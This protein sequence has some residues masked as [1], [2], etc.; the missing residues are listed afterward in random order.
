MT[1]GNSRR[2]NYLDAIASAVHARRPDWDF[3][4][5]KASLG[6][7]AAIAGNSSDLIDVG[8]AALKATQRRDR[9]SPS[10][11]AEPGTHWAGTDTAAAITPPRPC[12]NH[13]AEPAHACRQCR[14]EATP[15]PD[16]V[17]ADL[18]DIF[19]TRRRGP[20]RSPYTPEPTT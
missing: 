14:R 3:P 20:D 12:P 5:I 10:V 15:M 13:P 18:A 8:I 9:T 17:R 1:M 6:K 11:I 2:N 16:H 19:A 4:G 7:A